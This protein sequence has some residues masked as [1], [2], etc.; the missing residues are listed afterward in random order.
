LYRQ[1]DFSQPVEN[2]PAIK[3]TVSV[4]LCPSDNVPQAAFPLTDGTG[5]L[6]A[7]AAPSSYAATV[8]DDSC[9]VDN[10]T[11]NG[12]FYR[13]SWTRI[14]DITDG[15]SNTTL[16]G[17][18]AW[19]HAQGIWAGAPNLAVMRPGARNNWPNATGPSPTLVLVHNNFINITTDSD[20]GLDD[21][22]SNHTV[23]ANILFA[24]ASVHFIRSITGDGPARRA[25]WALGTRNGG[26]VI[27]GLDY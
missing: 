26:E 7:V 22:S 13:N 6:V 1:I 9:D 11:G 19:D 4:F 2:S 3:T 12:V 5:A 24:D 20:G 17:D 10:L 14:G 21:F 8:G 16:L 27:E 25:F 15:T 23:G 18:R